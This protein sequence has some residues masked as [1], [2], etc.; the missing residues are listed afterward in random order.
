MLR[1]IRRTFAAA[2]LGSATASASASATPSA[3]QNADSILAS[4]LDG[5]G[6]FDV[7]AADIDGDGLY[8]IATADLT[9]DG[10]AETVAM[11]GE[12]FAE[13]ADMAAEASGGVLDTLM[14]ILDA[15]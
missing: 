14:G 7:A 6:V 5:D 4:D 3:A 1:A 9:G 15:L 12:V 11:S 13:H 2:G 10:V 8:D